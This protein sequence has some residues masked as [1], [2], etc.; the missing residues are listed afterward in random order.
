MPHHI[1][2]YNAA[3]LPHLKRKNTGTKINDLFHAIAITAYHALVTIASHSRHQ[4]KLPAGYNLTGFRRR[5]SGQST[6]ES[7]NLIVAALAAL[8][9]TR[10]DP[11]G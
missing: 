7:F 2:S 9:K 4:L 11:A 6:G 5:I 3:C 1:D 8:K 10:P